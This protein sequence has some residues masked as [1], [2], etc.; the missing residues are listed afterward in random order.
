MTVVGH[1]ARKAKDLKSAYM[2]VFDHNAR[3][4]KDLKSANM[5]VICHD[6][7]NANECLPASATA[8]ARKFL[9]CSPSVRPTGPAAPD[10]GDESGET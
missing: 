2:T 5:T 9:H 4:A 6:A 1:D 3:N 10:A 8:C 7:R